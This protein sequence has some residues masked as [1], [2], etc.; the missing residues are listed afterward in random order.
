MTKSKTRTALTANGVENAKTTE[1]QEDHFDG[2][3][4]GLS[5]RVTKAGR[6]TWNFT[7]TS[8]VDGKRARFILGT[9]PALALKDARLKAVDARETVESGRD[10]REIDTTTPVDLT[11]AQVFEYR[12][13]KEIKEQVHPQTGEVT[14]KAMAGAVDM[15]RRFNKDIRPLVGNMLAKD[16]RVV[17]FHRVLDKIMDE[18]GSAR[19]AG[20]VGTDLKTLFTFALNQGVV[21]FSPLAKVKHDTGSKIRERFLSIEEIVTL[22]HA[23][24]T[25]NP[26]GV[27]IRRIIMLLLLTGQRLGEVTGMHR[28]EINWV[29]RVWT[30]PAERSKNT[31]AHPVPLSDAAFKIISEAA[32]DTNGDYLF[33]SPSKT[34]LTGPMDS[35]SVGATIRRTNELGRYGIA[36][37]N[38]HDLRRTVGTQMLNKANGLAISRFDKAL[39]L[40]H[41]SVTKETVS[42]QVYDMN[43][44][45]DEKREALTK[46]AAFI[47]RLVGQN[48]VQI[49]QGKA[50]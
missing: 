23:L 34:G 4:P 5:L 15:E 43:E 40:N 22:W 32:R 47:E 18:R 21:D 14:R 50:A 9:Y 2:L 42:D 7:F 30:I 26:E 29:T 3:C 35:G 41:R 19:V 27:S 10:P 8:P 48:V 46:W 45:L 1:A 33:P 16:F 38:A 17:H 13:K 44:Y 6:K 31:F 25:A 28:D 39:V 49:D 36:K 24:P 11:V 12:L 37:W 20:M